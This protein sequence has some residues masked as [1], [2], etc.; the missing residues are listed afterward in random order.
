VI[1]SVG[2]LVVVAMASHLLAQPATDDRRT[3]TS[4]EAPERVVVRRGQG[5]W[6]D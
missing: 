5:S 4:T 6:A 3:P 2:I 1:S